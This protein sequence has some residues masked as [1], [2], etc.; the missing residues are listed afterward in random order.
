MAEVRLSI[1]SV[2]ITNYLRVDIRYTDDPVAIVD[3][4]LFAPG[5][6][7]P[8][9]NIVFFDIDPKPVFVDVRDTDGGA[10]P[11]EL[12]TTFQANVGN[13]VTAFERRLYRVGGSQMEND[14]LIDPE[15]GGRE[16]TD[17][18]FDGKLVSGLFK[19][20]FR[21]LKEWKSGE[22]FNA[23]E[24]R[25]VGNSLQYLNPE[26]G[27]MDG[28]V[29]YEGEVWVVDITYLID[30]FAGSDNERA[31]S[32]ADIIA[33]ISLSVVNRRRVNVIDASSA[34]ITITAEVLAS[35]PEGEWWEF[36]NN[37]G[38][39]HQALFVT[40]GGDPI[41]YMKS[42][43]Q[44]FVIGIGESF[45]VAKKGTRY[46]VLHADPGRRMVGQFFKSYANVE[47]NALLCNGSQYSGD[48]YPSV[49][50]YIMSLPV[51]FAIN[52]AT[53]LEGREACWYY[54]ESGGN[55]YFRTP[56]RQNGFGRNLK[57]FTSRGT[58]ADRKTKLSSSELTW[59]YPG[60]K[61]DERIGK[62]RHWVIV[63]TDHGGE[64]FLP[65]P[66]K[67]TATIRSWH[68]PGSGKESYYLVGNGS[69]PTTSRTSQGH[70]QKGL[71]E[72]SCEDLVENVPANYGEFEFVRI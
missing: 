22:P 31:I 11:G 19:E 1:G 9:M 17:P 63:P 71:S 44:R 61:Q 45:K 51:N 57:N 12:L 68:K 65:Q 70:I 13:K 3:T 7:D 25:R 20:G 56:N 15:P 72:E 52:S 67:I 14:I 36:I 53:V 38:S 27:E 26:N 10:D 55:K 54:W 29:F 69:E 6:I 8:V 41:R 47:P 21:Y 60:G 40:Q 37:S 24:W 59:D 16:I 48:D 28:P 39:Q 50:D 62:H 46:E 35:V 43:R 33:D 49:W 32:W 5:D 30:Q 2:N 42:D 18:Y 66:T 64:S 4:K 23:H 58:D 34:R